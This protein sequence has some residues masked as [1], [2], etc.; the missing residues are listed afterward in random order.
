MKDSFMKEKPV[1]PLLVSMALPMVISMLVN[2]LYNIVDSFFVARISEQAM[3]ALSLVY[4]VQNLINAVAIGYG[5]GIN[6]LIAFYSGAGDRVSVDTA[7]TQGF[8]FAAIHGILITV[9]SIS[10]M[11]A[12][13]HMFTS[14]E[15][16]I[17]LG[18][19]YSTIVFMFSLVIMIG[20]S[21][22]KMFQSVGRMGMTMISMLCGCI[23]NIILDPLLIF[24]IGF[25]P[26]MGIAGAAW[27]TGIG[28]VITLAVYV[29]MYLAR[30]I[31][32]RIRRNYLKFNR[33]M[34][35]KL[36]SIGIP[37]ILNLALPS[38]LV[39]FLN[40]ILALYSQS[41]VVI[42]GIYYKLQT[43][44]YLPANGI[45]QGMR[46]II[47]YNYGAGEHKRVRRIYDMTLCMSCIIM[48]L[49]TVLCLTAS[50]QL[51]SLFT[52]NPETVLSGQKALRIISAG[53]IVSSVSVT[54]SGALEG[55]GKGTQ[56]LIISLFRYVVIII[57]A[58]FILCRI[59]GPVGV[60]SAFWITE[61]ITA[62]ISAVVYR[63]SIKLKQT[64]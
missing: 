25:F 49:G 64:N 28:Q 52:S 11:P 39:S 61:F 35:L 2:S 3:T 46:P 63:L 24:G 30:P 21:F 23:S 47:G 12:F 48:V 9:G 29:F 4:P 62:A 26:E 20:L 16:V 31:P 55:L 60:W 13:L 32:V 17:E 37:A 15:G 27:A 34:D 54:S 58:A 38:L 5:V 44:L 43:F 56:S 45:V 6:A 10:I 41:Y 1:L 42:L 40:G 33:S 59:W 14:D 7:A 22:E 36:Y 51:I 8:L 53:F 19:Q 18:I 50:K 57:P